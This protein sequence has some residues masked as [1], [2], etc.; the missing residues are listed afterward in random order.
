MIEVAHSAPELWRWMINLRW[1]RYIT[2]RSVARAPS[3]EETGTPETEFVDWQQTEKKGTLDSQSSFVAEGPRLG[4]ARPTIDH[5]N[6]V[7]E[8]GQS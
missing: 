2:G 5:S 8:Y 4:I 6:G 1:I 7:T 3:P